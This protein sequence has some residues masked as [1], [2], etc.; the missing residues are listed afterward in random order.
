MLCAFYKVSFCNSRS[1][2]AGLPLTVQFSN[3]EDE[4][5]VLLAN[6]R[7]RVQTRMVPSIPVP[8]VASVTF[9]DDDTEKAKEYE[10][11]QL[12]VF[13]VLLDALDND[14]DAK[15]AQTICDNLYRQWLKEW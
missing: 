12:R 3:F 6:G 13:D 5:Q 4:A 11:F 8:I 10:R 14:K 9:A 7:Y 1:A 15:Q 2:T